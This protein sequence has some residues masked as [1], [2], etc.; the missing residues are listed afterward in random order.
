MAVSDPTS[1]ASVLKPW[2]QYF[3]FYVSVILASLQALNLMKRGRLSVVVTKDVF[4]RVTETGEALFCSANLLARHAPVLIREVKAKLERTNRPQKSFDLEISQFGE[5]VRG[6]SLIAEHYFYGTSAL[7]H[8]PDSIPQRAVYLCVQGN[9]R[10]LIQTEFVAFRRAILD[11]KQETQTAGI[12]VDP[13]DFAKTLQKRIDDYS[14]RLM[15]AVQIEPGSYKLS[16]S[17]SYEN[18]ARFTFFARPKAVESSISFT[19]GPDVKT[20]LWTELKQALQ[21]AGENLLFD[22]SVE[23]KYPSYHPTN[24]RE[25]QVPA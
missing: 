14:G 11:Y 9:Y 19:V 3:G 25:G 2:M 18:P 23:M 8:I 1:T 13:G 7:L 5:K 6:N 22:R 16:V 12:S 15:T 21:T 17:V 24:V 20:L 4:F 10:D